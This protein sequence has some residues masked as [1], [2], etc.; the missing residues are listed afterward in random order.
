MDSKVARLLAVLSVS[1]AA[2]SVE[3]QSVMLQIRPRVGDTLH[4]WLEQEVEMTGMPA[5]C[6][7]QQN[8]LRA[9]AKSG[10]AGCSDTRTMTTRMQV[11]SRAIARRAT[12]DA[13]DMLAITDSVLTSTEKRGPL[14]QSP[15]Q[16]SPRTPVELRIATD[17]SVEVGAGPASDEMRSLL[18][19]MPATLS[20]KPISPGD[21]WVHEMRVPLAGEPGAK[22]LLRTIFQ[23]DSLKRNGDVAYISMRGTLSHDHSNG[24]ES[25]TSGSLTGTMRFDRRLGWITDTYA[26]ID[27]WSEVTSRSSRKPMDVHT[28]VVQSLHVSSAR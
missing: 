13:T 18:G 25:E 26:M 9:H 1:F 24:T 28:R 21:K 22:G 2:T 4:V 19:Q 11:Y 7:G 14:R 16:A 17:G 3:A 20:R 15:N 8:A 10:S 27:V 5:G 23:L 12:R 6:G